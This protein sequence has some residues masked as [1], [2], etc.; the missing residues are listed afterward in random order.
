MIISLEKL[1]NVKGNRYLFTRATNTAID[2]RENIHNFP[3]EART[4]KVVPTVLQL[5]L[6]N[7]VKFVLTKEEE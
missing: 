2:R 4:W 5:V 1:I 3:E 6:D 7:K